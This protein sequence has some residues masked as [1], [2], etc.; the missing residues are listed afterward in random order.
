[1]TFLCDMWKI[2]AE[3]Y[4]EFL[5]R[6][7]IKCLGIYIVVKDRTAIFVDEAKYLELSL[8]DKS[9]SE[10]EKQIIKLLERSEKLVSKFIEIAIKNQSKK[11]TANEKLEED[12]Q[13]DFEENLEQYGDEE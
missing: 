12:I 7:G 13:E 8:N 6:Y 11:E 10:A 2:S 3:E 4:M 9:F 1:M 5:A